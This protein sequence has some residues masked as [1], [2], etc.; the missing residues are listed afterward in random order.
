MKVF[1]ICMVV[2]F[3]ALAAAVA[4]QVLEMKTLFFF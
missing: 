4:F 3:L 2:S 1:S